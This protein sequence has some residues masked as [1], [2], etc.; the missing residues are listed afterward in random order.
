VTN[1]LRVR[2]AAALLGLAAVGTSAAGLVDAAPA[3]LRVAFVLL[4]G[5]VVPAF[6]CVPLA[7][8]WI[9]GSRAAVVAGAVFFVLS[10]H[11]MVS[12]VFRLT[13]AT[14]SLYAASVTWALVLTFLGLIARSWAQRSR[15][16]A[17]W[18]PRPNDAVFLLTLTALVAVAASSRYPFTVWED[19][20]DH[21]GYVRRVV[22]FDSMRPDHLL[23]W[24]VDATTS[25]PPDPRKGALHPAV[26]WV[27]H[28]ANADPEV[29]WSLLS[30]VFFPGFVL[31]FTAF[32]QALL[33]A[34]PLLLLCV[35]LFLLSY[36]GTA[37]QLAH[38]APYGQNLAAAWYWLL[39]AIVLSPARGVRLGKRLVAAAILS[40]GGALVH[41]GVLLHAA[42]L[43]A[44]LVVFARGV[45]LTYRTGFAYA[46]TILVAAG[47]A[48]WLRLGT[49]DWPSNAIHTHVQGV[50][51]VGEG[52]SFV[53]SP[54]E[55][56]R[57][58]GMAYLGGIFLL[59][60]LAFVA[61]RRSDARAVAALCALPVAIAFVPP[62]AT[63]LYAKGSYMVFRSLLNAPV[64]AASAIV[65]A[66]AI[67]TARA[68]GVAVRAAAAILIAAWALA[69]VRPSVDATLADA[70]RRTPVAS[71]VATELVDYVAALPAG[72]T[73]L[74]DP[75]TAYVLSARTPHRFVAILDQHANPYDP[76]ALD[77]LA[78]VRDALSPFVVP[79][80]CIDACR[81]YRVDVVVVNAKADRGPFVSVWDA[82]L[83]RPTLSR[84][85]AVPSLREMHTADSFAAFV[86]DPV[87]APPSVPDPPLPP[88]VVESPP[89]DPCLV[90][91]PGR[92][93]EVIG[94]A[95]NPPRAQP[96]DSVT[97]TIGY[98][99][100]Q[101]TPFDFP[102]LVH[103]RFDHDTLSA[104]APYPGDKYVR[105]F[106]ERRRG[107]I[108]RFRA[109][110]R[111]G[112]GVFDPDL[113]AL[114]AE[115]CER[116][117]VV[118]PPY[119]VP[120]RY[121]VEVAVVRD[122]LV[123]NFHLRDLVYNHDHY[124]GTACTSLVVG[125]GP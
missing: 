96:G 123:P 11:A 98:R 89:L 115:L 52:G 121:R 87:A 119:A 51:F 17:A 72:S 53:M 10:L 28:L 31:A 45:G 48:T 77:R 14:F 3:P 95:S 55:I 124:S 47:T 43:A 35:A 64:F 54:M 78:A 120:G 60:V 66:W 59:P 40:L 23:A 12:E 19:A 84:L 75:A 32:S 33:R 81:R 18:R 83:Y 8:R 34:R 107:V 63:A 118:V 21:I 111:P 94:V 4:G 5:M 61:R 67:D 6:L 93:F 99:R 108:T 85:H 109:D 106:E 46:A 70:S 102:L 105:R 71:G 125:D 7:R 79:D 100:D 80:R 1:D 117:T 76:Y 116:V 86:F 69:F 65:L 15:G 30:L 50:L 62:V 101:P 90:T 104:R 82:V 20:F 16:A 110:L 37:F 122:S 38:A 44:S 91:V 113:W 29:V 42:V 58:H 68:R 92:A 39:A 57:Q 9:G 56:L 97:I 36:A 112:A 103:V 27:G 74:T 114:G 25:L 22:T 13:G 49:A 88:V 73:I 24:P 26:A 2:T 41:V